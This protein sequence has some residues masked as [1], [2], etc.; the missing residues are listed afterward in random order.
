MTWKW[1]P[2]LPAC[3]AWHTLNGKGD[4]PSQSPLEIWKK[5]IWDLK[6]HFFISYLSWAV[7]W[8][9]KCRNGYGKSYAHFLFAHW[10]TDIFGH[11]WIDMSF[12]KW[13]LSW[14]FL[15]Q[16]WYFSPGQLSFLRNSCFSLDAFFLFLSFCF[17]FEYDFY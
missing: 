16:N 6:T 15:N 11:N 13:K 8:W 10:I 2:C 7:T 1:P 5:G 14:H 4:N 3:L 17:C 12:G 9:S